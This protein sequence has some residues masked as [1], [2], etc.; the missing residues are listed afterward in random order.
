MIEHQPGEHL[1]VADAAAGIAVHFFH[2]LLDGVHPV[3]HDVAGHPLRHRHQL[4]V[5]HQHPVVIAGDEALDDDAPAVLAR[6]LERRPHLLFG[7][8]V[9][10]DA[11]AVVGVEWLYHHRVPDPVRRRDRVV[12][13]LH[14]PLARHGQAE[15][16]E[17]AVGL[18][19]VGGQLDR[20]VRRAARDRGLDPLLESAVAELDQALLVEPDPGDPPVLGR[21]HERHGARPERAPLGEPDELVAL[22]GEVEVAGDGALGPKVRGQERVEQ[23]DA[24]S[25]GLE[26]DVLLLVLVEDVVPPVRAG[27]AGLAEGHRLAGHVLQLDGDMLEDVPHPGALVLTQPPDEPARLA[28]GAAVLVQPRQRLD[29]TVDEGRPELG[30]RPRLERAEVHLETDDGEV[31]VQAGADVDGPVQNAHSESF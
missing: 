14:Q 4:A 25:A 9:D 27:A 3:A 30:G 8:E 26:A 21:P 22:G 28:V 13:A 5:D 7:R 20:D 15:V 16:G 23:G 12:L 31:G 11:A 1:L 19:L 18:L 6:H 24:Q 17:D 2:Q 10:R 29:E